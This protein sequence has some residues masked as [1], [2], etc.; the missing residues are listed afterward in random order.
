MKRYTFN[1]YLVALPSF[2]PSQKG[3]CHQTI[4][5]RAKDEDGARELA[6]YLTGRFT[7]QVKQVNY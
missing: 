7:G 4:L 3:W 6:R 2:S 1:K 5:V